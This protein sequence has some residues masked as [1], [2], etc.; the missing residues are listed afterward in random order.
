LIIRRMKQMG[1]LDSAEAKLKAKVPSMQRNW[2]DGT[3]RAISNG[4]YEK[5]MNEV[6]PA[7][8]HVRAALVQNFNSGIAAAKSAG[9]YA[10]GVSAGVSKWRR[11]YESKCFE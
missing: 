4:S 9:T 7:G 5:G 6:A 10:S 11:N 1:K 8:K 2:D 3:S